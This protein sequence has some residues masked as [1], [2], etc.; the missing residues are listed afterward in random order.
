[1]FNKNFNIFKKKYTVVILNSQWKVLEKNV[2]LEKI[3]R[4]NEYIWNGKKYYRVVNIVHNTVSTQQISL[5]VNEISEPEVIV[6]QV[7]I[8]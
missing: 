6:N 8:K 7:D 2:K 5:I 3:P 4:I 1:M